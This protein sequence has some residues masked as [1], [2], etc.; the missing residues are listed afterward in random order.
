[1]GIEGPSTPG[2]SHGSL[3]PPLY[4]AL[5]RFAQFFIALLFLKSTLDR[6]L[7]AVDSENKKNLQSDRRCL[8]QRGINVRDEF[9]KFHERQYSANRM[10]LVIILGRESLGESEKWAVE[11]FSGVKNR[12]LP[13]NRWD[14]V[15]PFL[16]EHLGLRQTCDGHA[17]IGYIFPVSRRG[18]SV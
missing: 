5:D 17:I 18:R 13:Q 11:L 1:V 7:Q 4:G 10:K 2:A 14:D 3:V 8:T 9:V 15:Q 12:R 16:E 6:E